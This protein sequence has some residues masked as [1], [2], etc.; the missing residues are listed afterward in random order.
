MKIYSYLLLSVLILAMRTLVADPIKL[1]CDL[2]QPPENSGEDSHMYA[3]LFK[4]YPRAKNIP[5]NY[6]GCQI[7]WQSNPKD[8]KFPLKWTSVSK[9]KYDK[10]EVKSVEWGKVAEGKEIKNCIYQ[11]G[12]IIS[13]D[14]CYP[15]KKLPLKSMAPG[16]FKKLLELTK[17]READRKDKKIDISS[18]SMCMKYE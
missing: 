2:E 4:I 5:K 6:T 18:M 7:T 8:N 3:G 14:N 13:G 10:G 1:N 12:N 9:I 15:A 16:C 17:N 11:E